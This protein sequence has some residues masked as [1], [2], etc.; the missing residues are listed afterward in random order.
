M[1]IGLV[2]V[3]GHNF[4]SLTLMKLSA[5]HKRQGDT[6]EWYDH[7]ANWKLKP[8]D[9]VY[10]SK[11]FTFTP[12]Y[13]YEPNAQQIIKSGTGYCY[14]DGGIPLMNEIEYI[15]PDYTLYP[16]YKSTAYGFLTRGCP[17]NCDFCCVTKKEGCRT[18]KVAN[19]SNFWNGQIK[20]KLL[21]P[22]ITACIN[23]YE[24]FEQ[25]IDSKAKID[26]TQGMRIHMMTEEKA[27]MI[28][29]MKIERIHF[30]WDRY[31]DMN[32]V[33]PRLR[34]FAQIT[35]WD[36]RKM[37]VYVLVNFDT[38]LDQDLERIYAIRDLGYWPS[39]MVYEKEKLPQK[40]IL[41]RLQR[42]VNHRA[43]FMKVK[44]FNDYV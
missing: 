32:I 9:I 7:L 42:W 31:E 35:K 6:V 25:L 23:W 18:I 29:Q 34:D 3:D 16:K 19:L 13:Q 4:P 36:F 26:F 14:P 33:I 15:Y 44:N 12:D 2:D 40:H 41:K 17:C 30:A 22:N 8:F 39:V 28:K 38:T 43:I 20:V 27:E 10:M 1:K 21:D 11:V 5:W 24:L 37:I